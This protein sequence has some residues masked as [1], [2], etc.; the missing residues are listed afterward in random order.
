MRDFDFA[1]EYLRELV[2]EVVD[3]L[4]GRYGMD[5]E[6]SRIVFGGLGDVSFVNSWSN[7]SEYL[8]MDGSRSISISSN[9]TTWFSNT[10]LERRRP[11]LCGLLGEGKRRGYQ[12]VIKRE[13]RPLGMTGP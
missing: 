4:E 12:R 11:L 8:L 9:L 2:A 10:F 1:G 13:G 6:G 7:G 3:V 5:L